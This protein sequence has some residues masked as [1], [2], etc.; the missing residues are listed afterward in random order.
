MARKP[1]VTRTIVTTK[2]TAL[3]LDLETAEPMNK[4]FV[5]PRTYKDN[6]EI[7]KVLK[8]QYESDTLSIAQ[9]VNVEV[10]ETLYGMDE[11]TFIAHATILPARNIKTTDNESEG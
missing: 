8:K 9:V 10:I 4:E 1:Q 7:L 11:E 6:K 5:L 2:A 3:C